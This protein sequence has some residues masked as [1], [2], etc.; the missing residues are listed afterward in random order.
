MTPRF[1]AVVLATLALLLALHCIIT[2]RALQPQLSASREGSVH[3]EPGTV[4]FPAKTDPGVKQFAVLFGIKPEVVAAAQN[5]EPE[6]FGANNFKLLAVDEQGGKY[7][8]MIALTEGGSTRLVPLRQGESLKGYTVTQ[9]SLSHAVLEGP[10]E[11]T[12]K[13]FSYHGTKIKSETGTN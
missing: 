4:L 10:A 5:T 1:K 2:W 6:V 11:L 13:L 12:L 7:R 8:A 9:L 3:F